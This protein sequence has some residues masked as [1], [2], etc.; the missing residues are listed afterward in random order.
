MASHYEVCVF[1]GLFA[2]ALC[3]C[4]CGNFFLAYYRV[5]R[6]VFLGVKSRT[7]EQG[8]LCSI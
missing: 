1:F 5:D 8:V 6:V 4:V 7:S 3:V 2:F